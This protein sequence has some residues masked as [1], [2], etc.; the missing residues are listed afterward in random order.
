LVG[1]IIFCT[2]VLSLIPRAALQNDVSIIKEF[3]PVDKRISER[4]ETLPPLTT[5]ATATAPT[6]LRTVSSVISGLVLVIIFCFRYESTAPI[7]Q[8]VGSD[9]KLSQTSLL[10]WGR[11]TRRHLIVEIAGYKGRPR[12]KAPFS[13][14]CNP[15]ALNISILNAKKADCSNVFR[16]TNPD[17]L[18]SGITYPRQR[19]SRATYPRQRGK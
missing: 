8:F 5:A 3:L 6:T 13:R 14:I 18:K 9:A 4:K 15:T 10:R 16:I 1:S 17:T 19:G 7:R 11:E 2:F 12:F